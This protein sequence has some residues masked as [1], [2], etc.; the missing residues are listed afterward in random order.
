M[1]I[2]FLNKSAPQSLDLSILTTY[3]PEQVIFYFFSDDLSITL[4]NYLQ[5]KELL[6]DDELSPLASLWV[7]L[8]NDILKAD[9][10]LQLLANNEY[11]DFIGPYYYPAAN[12]RFYFC[13][14]PPGPAETLTLQDMGLLE[15]LQ[16]IDTPESSVQTY[17]R[18]KKGARRFSRNKDEILRDV[19]MCLISISEI[20][21][22]HKKINF[23]EKVYQCRLHFIEEPDLLP[24]EPDQAPVKPDKPGADTKGKLLLFTRQ[25]SGSQRSKNIY[26]HQLKIYYIRYREY[27][28]ACDR[29]KVILEKWPELKTDFF[30]HCGQD[31][32]L[33]AEKLLT[34]R[35]HMELYEAIIAKSMVHQD[36]QDAKTLNIF[37]SYLDTGRASDLQECMNLFEEECLW[38]EL[39]AGQTRIENTIY[40]LQNDNVHLN[41]AQA[42][43]EDYLVQKEEDSQLTSV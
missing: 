35:Q 9:E 30:K 14:T 43:I 25:R 26:Q 13:K 17:G 12:V 16:E 3:R 7:A 32:D 19:R 6:S 10:D 41:Q 27:E 37:Q 23:W 2:S 20:E 4:D 1:F 31:L 34:A 24:V 5:L 11:L 22:L 15:Q 28:K 39:K 21:K 38:N 18:N 42:H 8:I 36:Y 29:F 33:A 40:L